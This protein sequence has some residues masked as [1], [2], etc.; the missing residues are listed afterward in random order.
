M[1]RRKAREYVFGEQ[2]HVWIEKKQNPFISHASF[3][4]SISDVADSIVL[5]VHVCAT[6]FDKHFYITFRHWVL[7]NCGQFLEVICIKDGISLS[8]IYQDHSQTQVEQNRSVA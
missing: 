3:S 8:F 5:F 6:L 7:V 1:V 4:A 2:M